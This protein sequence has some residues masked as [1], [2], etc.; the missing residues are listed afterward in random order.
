MD[1]A[2]DAASCMMLLFMHQ[3]RWTDAAQGAC[4][5]LHWKV[6]AT[7]VATYYAWADPV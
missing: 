3:F 4:H 5:H 1:P 2:T 7:L 6:V